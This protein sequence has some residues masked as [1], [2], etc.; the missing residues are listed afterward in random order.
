M[1][2]GGREY[3]AERESKIRKRREYKLKIERK[4]GFVRARI[5]S[6]RA[7]GVYWNSGMCVGLGGE[8]LL[9]V[10][11]ESSETFFFK[12]VLYVECV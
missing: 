10:W 4:G 2:Y 11:A 6:V 9:C 3:G 12:Y 7:F 8:V 1:V 5:C